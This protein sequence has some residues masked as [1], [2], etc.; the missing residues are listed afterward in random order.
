M[1]R[2]AIALF[3]VFFILNACATVPQKPISSND[4]PVLKGQWAGTRELILGFTRTF[5]YTEMEVFNDTL[6][7]KGKVI[8]HI[9][10]YTGVEIRTYPFE[11]GQIDQ[12]G[13][14]IV[15]LPEDN[16]MTLS[17]YSSETTKTL[18]GNFS[19]K[20]QPGKIVLHKK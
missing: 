2:L 18:Y 17:F 4:L 7:V 11:D 3:A 5:A 8:I 12:T 15:R 9:P 1:K 20:A 6:P 19:H 16:L 14:L 13:K 10:T